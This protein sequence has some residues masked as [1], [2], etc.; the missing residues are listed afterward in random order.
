ML[1]S[2]WNIAMLCEKLLFSDL[3]E[4][5]IATLTFLPFTAVKDDEQIILMVAHAFWTVGLCSQASLRFF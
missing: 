1:Q 4:A 2:R 5:A 3:Y